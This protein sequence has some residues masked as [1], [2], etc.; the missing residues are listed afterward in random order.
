MS[1]SVCQCGVECAYKGTVNEPCWGKVKPT[2]DAW[3]GIDY[4]LVHACSGH[5]EKYT[6]GKYT[7]DPNG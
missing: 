1:Y 4:D 3:N 2:D 5:V 6:K 7:K